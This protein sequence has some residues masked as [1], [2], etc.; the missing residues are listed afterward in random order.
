VTDAFKVMFD[1]GPLDKDPKTRVLHG[2]VYLATDPVAMDTVGWEL[3]DQ[4]RKEHALKSLKDSKR[5]PRYI[6]TAGE[7]G[8]GIADRNA[9][10]F[11]T[12]EV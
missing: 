9:I 6:Q 2:S 12:Y 5:E 1:K 3:V 8:L 4:L 10:R 11:K 7:L